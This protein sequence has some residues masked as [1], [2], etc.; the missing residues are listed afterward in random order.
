MTKLIGIVVLALTHSKLLR[1]YYFKM[2]LV[3]IIS[4][5]LHGL[6]FLP[7]ALSYQG[8]QGYA[9]GDDHDEDYIAQHLTSNYS[10]GQRPFLVHDDDLSDESDG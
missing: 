10:S 8:G 3:L 5:A 9:S 2:W 7:V 6:V 4:G 1:T